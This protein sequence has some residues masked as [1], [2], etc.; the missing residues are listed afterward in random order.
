[1]TTH[2]ISLRSLCWMTTF[3]LLATRALTVAQT[4]AIPQP[5]TPGTNYRIAGTVV[6]KVDGH[7]LARARITVRDAK[8][9]HKFESLVSAEDGRFQFST[10]PAG[11]Y[12]LTGA[13][14][15]FITASYEQHEQF[16][17]AIVTGA[18]IDTET[19]VLRL[20][21]AAIISG[22][23]LDEAGEPVRHA[24]VTVYYDDHSSGVDQIRQSHVTQTDDLGAY[25]IT[26][27]MPGTY[28]LSASATPWY[29][30]HPI[31]TRSGS[32]PSADTA[33]ADGTTFDRSLDVAYPLTYYADV[34]EADSAAPIPI[35]GGERLQVEIHLNPVPALHLLFRVHNN[36]NRGDIFPRLEQPAFDGSTFLQS[37]MV[38]TVS[39][40]LVEITGVPAGRYNVH[41]YG[42]GSGTQMNGVDLNK[43]G[44]EL[45]TST[46]EAL[47]TVKISVHLSGETSLPPRLTLALQSAHRSMAGV[48]QVN[49]QGEVE[50]QQIPS[51][52]YEVLSWGP[53]KPYS[54]A[55][56]SAEGA[57]V[58]GHSLV[59][60]PGSS[61]EVS[62]TLVGGSVNVEGIAKHAGTPFAGAMV[63]LVPKHPE[64]D[65]ELFRRDQ[66]DLDGTFSL[67]NVVPGS[68]T[69]LAIENGWD[70][71]WSEAGVIAAYLSH[72]R[73][74]EVGNQVGRTQNVSQAVEVQSK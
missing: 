45:D 62:L 38:R 23:V 11:K 4:P 22:K 48:Q 13:K 9:E 1:M 57:E 36:G 43:D 49:P 32:S 68:Y 59:V 3:S 67:R 73:T 42:A 54:I 5:G 63:V 69:L 44:E 31:A 37:D 29:A 7:P 64:T 39:P 41:F 27:L 33:N 35:R 58:S 56:I 15:G 30:V 66:S 17:T 25:E 2:S 65:R 10:V 34:T 6:S 52:R 21:P 61:P 60:A 51:G 53:P 46:A 14:R 40:G 8:D 47:S 26:P 19:L 71:E 16:S 50:F 70:L 20:A 12:S 72:G 28:F 55:H 74:I 24:T 18:G